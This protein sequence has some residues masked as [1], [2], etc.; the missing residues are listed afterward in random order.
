MALLVLSPTNVNG[1]LCKK[2]N[3]LHTINVLRHPLWGRAQETYGEDALHLGVLGTAFVV[4]AQSHVIASAKHLAVNRV[5]EGRCVV[6]VGQMLALSR[7]FCIYYR[8]TRRRIS[9]TTN[10]VRE[11]E[12]CYTKS[13]VLV[14]LKKQGIP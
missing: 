14:R 1:I 5:N 6:V 10:P 7:S 4:G 8:L 9:V 12:M 2:T 11:M 3:L 13:L